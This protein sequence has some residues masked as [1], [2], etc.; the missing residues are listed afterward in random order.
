[1]PLPGDDLFF[2]IHALNPSEKRYFKLFAQRQGNEK[3]K[4]Y[5]KVFDLID[6][7]EEAYDEELLKKKLKSKGDIKMLPQLKIYLFD[8]IVKSMRVYRSEKN[9]ANEVFDLIQDELFYTEKGLTE[10]R[11]KALRRA[12]ELAYKFDL[13]YM[14]VAILQRERVFAIRY[15]GGDPVA[16]INLIHEEEQR[17]FKSLN[18]ESELGKIYYTLLAQFVIDPKLNDP[19]KI[20]W[21]VGYK[22]HPLLQDIN[23]IDTYYSKF[24]FLKCHGYI[25]RFSNDYQGMYQNNL[26]LL[27]LMEQY[28]QHHFNV[29]GNYMDAI[30]SV[31]SA[32]H[33]LGKYEEFEGLLKKLDELPK[34]KLK[35]EATIAM[36]ILHYKMLYYMNTAQFDKSEEIINECEHVLKKYSNQLSDSQF[37]SDVYNLSLFLFCKGDIHKSL[38]YCQEVL[39]FKSESK[40][41][42]QHG[43]QMLHLLLHYELGNTVYLDSA[44]R[45]GIRSMQNKSRFNDFEKSFTGYIKKLIKTAERE[46]SGVYKEMYDFY[47]IMHRQNNHKR[48]VLIEE[49][50][51]W[52]VS[53]VENK[54]LSETIFYKYK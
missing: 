53:K 18:N 2:L 50:L 24:L 44:L 14:L 38:H 37:V 36:N 22:N 34:D 10:M 12:K 41:D 3:N 49:T 16:K 28:P 13:T 35:D 32:A 7:Q 4:V 47:L 6:E 25:Y 1:M 5:M 9:A 19:Q 20:E 39:N 30:A 33:N 27:T 52:A 54:P 11:V 48:L 15:S 8:L 26:A 43:A 29:L 23:A 46:K 31:L 51:A 45:N 40:Q 21:L 17:V 42:L